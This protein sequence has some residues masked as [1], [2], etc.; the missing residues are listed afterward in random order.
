M[1]KVSVIIPV[2]NVEKYLKQCLDSIV[3]QTLKEI[4]IICVDDGSSDNSL[5][6]LRDYEKMD[7]RVIVLTQ[8]N[9]GAGVARNAGMQIAQG[10]YLSILDSDDFFELDM[11]EQAYLQ[12]KK[13]DVD[14]CV[15][16]SDQYDNVNDIYQDIPWTIKQRYLPKTTPFSAQEIA[17]YI[18]QIFNGWSWD[19]LYRRS[20]VEKNGLQFQGL[21]TTNDAFFVFM[22]NAQAEKIT[23][24]DKILAHHRVNTKTSLSV[25]REKSWDCCYQAMNAI[26]LEL[27]NRKQYQLVE[28]SFIN[29]ALH[30]SLWN[31]RTLQGEA[32]ENLVQ[33]LKEKYFVEL[34]IGK[35][36]K[37]YFY[38]QDEYRQYIEIVQS[39]MKSKA[40]ENLV[41]KTINYYRENGLRATVRR[42]IKTIF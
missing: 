1:I 6:I 18:F 4:E 20:F 25:T 27:K 14:F 23:I 13:D 21:R 26:K 37:E 2:Y 38:N 28:Q 11:L 7:S 39:G 34:E 30:F 42:I 33:A 19:K 10:E 15:F 8:A 3:N 35:Y 41:S 40:K 17:P 32:K 9:S 22:T 16:R 5:N 36:P 29:W 24:V 12:C 31:V